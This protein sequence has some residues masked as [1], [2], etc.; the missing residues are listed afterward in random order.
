[1]R[2]FKTPVL[3]P[4]LLMG[5]DPYLLA[6][7]SAVMAKKCHYLPV[8]DGPRMGRPDAEAEV[9]RRN[10]A[11]VRAKAKTIVMANLAQETRSAFRSRFPA[12]MTLS[13]QVASEV[14]TKTLGAT[15][16]SGTPLT[17]GRKHIAI[18]LLKALRKKVP[19]T[20][21]DEEVEERFLKPEE[22]HLVVCEEDNE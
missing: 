1:M 16:R 21:T 7:L 15:V 14:T 6:E 19:I 2:S 17:W 8:I 22:G 4:T 12:N 5:D 20:F 9:I 18:G 11:V 10:N 3:L 13:V